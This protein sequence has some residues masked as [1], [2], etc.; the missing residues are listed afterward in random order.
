MKEKSPR[1]T[2]CSEPGDSPKQPYCGGKLKR[3]TALEPEVAKSAGKGLDVF[4]CQVCGILYTE[5][6]AYAPAK[7]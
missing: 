6:S 3:I 4:R 2:V 7:H 5:V 1:Q